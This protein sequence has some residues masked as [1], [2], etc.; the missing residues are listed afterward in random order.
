MS[1]VL[2]QINAGGVS[3]GFKAVA[4][5]FIGIFNG[6]QHFSYRDD[7]DRIWDAFYI[8]Q[9]LSWKLQQINLG[10]LTQGPTAVAGPCIGQFNNQQH[11]AYVDGQGVA[12]DSWYDGDNDHW[13]LQ[14]RSVL[15]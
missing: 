14:H 13:N 2:H 7:S 9:N 10:V 8:S 5:P 6:Q 4:S 11:F 1:N 15:P 12:W 3:N